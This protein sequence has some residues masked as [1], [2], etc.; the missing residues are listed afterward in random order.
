MPYNTVIVFAAYDSLPAADLN[1]NFANLDYLLTRVAPR[2]SQVAS[3]ATPSINVDN[4]NTLEITALATN[5]TSM[6][7]GLTGTPSNW[8]EL[9][10]IIKDNGVARSIVW[11]ASFVA[12]GSALPTTTIAGKYLIVGL[13]YFSTLSKWGCLAVNQEA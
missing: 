13:R 6:T 5:I 8:Q 3:S 7:S 10:Y 4:Y 9:F 2:V 11:G 12:E 1:S